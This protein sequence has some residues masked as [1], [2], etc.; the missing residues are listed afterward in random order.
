MNSFF[1]SLIIAV[2]SIGC[3]KF[4]IK[5]GWT[6]TNFE[7]KQIPYNL[8]VIII[9][10][11][12]LP[13]VLFYS[14]EILTLQSVI[15][16]TLIWFSGF[17]D[18]RYGDKASKGFRGHILVLL[19]ERKISTGIVKIIVTGMASLFFVV[20]TSAVFNLEA[21]R[22][23][24]LLLLLPHI[25]NLFDTRPLRASKVGLLYVASLL[26]FLTIVEPISFI[27]FIVVCSVIFVFEGRKL[28]ML[29]DNGATTIGA[30]LA[31]ITIVHGSPLHQWL[32][33]T[34]SFFLTLLAEK[35]SFSKVIARSTFLSRIDR[36][37][38]N[39]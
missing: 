27:Y 5:N 6:T 10:A 15:Y 19:H 28:A 32:T 33:I 9:V 4:F 39:E 1:L 38:T 13:G 18:D 17:I 23:L 36:L 31:V 37:G 16:V 8:G 29:G 26:P 3:Y 12:F 22:I 30:I 34:I 35:V 11:F 24:L 14:N 20:L 2:V 7:G 25:F 21:V